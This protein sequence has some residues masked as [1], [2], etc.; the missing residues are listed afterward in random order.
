MSQLTTS[1]CDSAAFHM[2]RYAVERLDSPVALIE[3]AFAIARHELGDSIDIEDVKT[4]IAGFASTVRSR[5]RGPQQQALIAHLHEVL[6]V[7]NGF[8]GNTLN[9]HDPANSYLPQVLA[10]RRGLPITLSLIY[11]AV[12]EQLGLS[13]R[14][15]GLPGHFCC[16]V[17]TDSGLMIIDSFYSG[18]LLSIE[19]ARERIRDTYGPEAAWNDELLRP[20]TNR[21]WLTR[22]MQNLLHTFS[23][24]ER[25]RDVAAMLELEL[26]LW[27]DQHHLQ[28]DLA[29]VLARLGASKR[30][31]YWLSKYLSSNP[32]DPQKR[33]LTELLHALAA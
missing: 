32:H 6:F 9:Y 25:F 26:L 28:R 22:I 5:V 18:R 31:S 2:M 29:L 33:D 14:G 19:D 13:I 15:L 11:K 20:V 4:Q 12:G 30:A 17:E 7:E 3:G 21:H 23:Q 10:T 8:I 27:P 24:Q 1:I 16:G